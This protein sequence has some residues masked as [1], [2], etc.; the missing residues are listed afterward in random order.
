[1]LHASIVLSFVPQ[2]HKRDTE[3]K[4]HSFMDRQLS[5]F[6]LIEFWL[7]LAQHLSGLKKKFSLKAILL[8]TQYTACTLYVSSA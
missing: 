3:L 6:F 7:P 1:M 4:D 2:K 5:G 8:F